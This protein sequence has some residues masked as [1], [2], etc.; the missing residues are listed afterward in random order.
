MERWWPAT[1]A[2][3]VRPRKFGAI[4]LFGALV[5][6]GFLFF[7]QVLFLLLLAS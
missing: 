3:Q 5:V 2:L 1:T 7:T 6:L 4:N